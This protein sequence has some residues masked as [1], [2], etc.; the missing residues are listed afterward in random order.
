M[1]KYIIKEKSIKKND[2]FTNR[3]S[4]SP[5]SYRKVKFNNNNIKK[6]EELLKN[7]RKGFEPGSDVYTKF[8]DNYFIRITDLSTTNYTFINTEDT[9]KLSYD[10]I[11]NKNNVIKNGDICFQTASDVGNVCIYNGENAYYNSHIIKLDLEE[12]LKYY[13][14]SILKSKFGTAQVDV[15]GSI[16]GVDN[17]NDEL[18]LNINIPFP[19][20]QDD[21]E[22]E[23]IVK[24]ISNITQNII[25]KEELIRKKNINID[26]AI[27]N[28]LKNNQ[29]NNK[30]I[31][32]YPTKE[33]FINFGRIDASI[34]ERKVKEIEFKIKN[35]KNGYVHMSELFNYSRGQNLQVS[36]I[37]E[38]IYS[39]IEKNNFYRMFTNI[40]M[41][42]DRTI[43]GFRWLGNKNKLTILPDNAVMLAADGLIVGRSFFY[44]RMENTITNLHP[45]IITPKDTSMPI[46]ERV[47]LSVYLSY[48]KN[49]GYLN[50]IKDKSNGGGLKK[51][52]LD[53]WIII[54]KFSNETKKKIASEYYNKL[55][56]NKNLSL[57]NY[58]DK[59]ILRNTQLGI[60]QLNMELISLKNKLEKIID[61]LVL[62]KPINID[63]N[64]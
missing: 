10:G 6:L 46:Y 25:N 56:K 44:D 15:G 22:N 17:F 1:N 28:E 26:K 3:C 49:I 27:E 63:F 58:L 13:I 59:E 30:F 23:N 34:Y 14:F 62:G 50:R 52:H 2:M 7:K 11:K 64:Y 60:Y 33:T 48:L 20:Y 21:K 4:L 42:D 12:S 18:L 37:G 36:Q 53:K 35:Y 38:S 29:K 57:D 32:R 54:P 16:K 40:E 19:N 5:F 9:V 61:N 47:F 24:Y 41:Q 31:Y 45:W 51:N 55:D 39:N 43:S 8:G